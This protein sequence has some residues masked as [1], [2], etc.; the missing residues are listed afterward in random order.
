MNIEFLGAV[1][2]I[3]RSAV[4]VND[5]ILLDFGLKATS[6]PTLP[7][8]TPSPDA[9]IVSHGHLDHVGALPAIFSGNN[10]PPIYW[11]GPTSEFAHLLA[12]DTLNLH[13]GTPRCPFTIE[14][15]HR[16]TE[17]SR[18]VGERSVFNCADHRVEFY[19]AGH[20]PGSVHVVIDDGSTRLLYT[21]DFHTGN[22]SLIKRSTDR[23][24]ADLVITE[25]TYWNTT[26]PPRESI[27]EQCIDSIQ[28]TIWNGG[29]VVIPAFAI[30]RTQ[31]MFLL[32]ADADIPC[33]IDGMGIAVTDIHVDHASFLRV[34]ET[35]RAANSHA[36]RVTNHGT[37]QRISNEAVA[38]ITTSGMLAGGPAME[39]IPA[40]FDHPRN[41]IILVGHQ[42]AGTPGRELL[43]TGRIP[44]ND[45]I[46]SVSAQIESYDF[47]AHADRAGI[48]S[49]LRDYQDVPI[50][51]THG[52]GCSEFANQ[53]QQKGFDA[54][55]PSLG[56]LV[57]CA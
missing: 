16:M 24:P 48:V 51:V 20:I 9:V 49:F 22:Q 26:R 3:G 23:P 56:E 46:F 28:T 53:L 4:L 12:Q 38:I 15:I 57:E 25:S 31:E 6:P 19:P 29:T 8:R 33:Y 30:G 52:D 44:I 14:E 13:G 18:I 36:R 39:Y 17:C 55:A 27:A 32:C 34:P 2:E 54:H 47:S 1:Q 10:R 50:L 41:K 37:R 35:F 43:D 21:G 42:V 5:S 7:I 11:T 45:R 40:I